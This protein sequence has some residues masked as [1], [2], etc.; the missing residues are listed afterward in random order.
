M[1]RALIFSTFLL[2]LFTTGLAP[3]LAPDG[4]DGQDA[5]GPSG[6]D[7]NDGLDARGPS[8]TNWNDGLDTRG[9][10]GTYGNDGQDAW[11]P[12]GTYGND[13]QDARGPSGTYGNDGQDARGPSGTY[14]N[15][16]QDAGGPSGTNGAEASENN[17]FQPKAPAVLDSPIG[18]IDM[19]SLSRLLNLAID[20]AP[21]KTEAGLD[22]PS[23]ILAQQIIGY[24]YEKRP[25]TGYHFGHGTNTIIFVGGLHGGYEWN[26]ILLAYQAI[27]YFTKHPNAV[28]EDVTLIIIPS[29][30]PDGQYA[31][32]RKEGP[33]EQGDVVPSTAAGR[34]NGRGVDLNRNWDCAWQP[35]AW[36]RDLV[37]SGGKKPFSEPES[38]ALRDFFLAQD[39]EV[40]IFWHS[41][42]G[43]V[44]AAGCQEP[45]QPSRDLA[46]IYGSASGY[47][48]ANQFSYY[49]VTGDAS[50]W[51][52]TQGIPSFT[53]ELAS[54]DQIEWTENQSGMMAILKHLG[55]P[56]RKALLPE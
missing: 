34:F 22:P 2:F 51:L 16:G 41:K 47:P 5:R 14:G 42:A 11:G 37:V 1:F 40:V 39:P 56:E 29:A 19:E 52:S 48:V 3:W 54:H 18:S 53:V 33:F 32:T 26:T 17:P 24:S 31:V 49:E 9:P 38:R 4:N 27:D 6:T 43:G 7:G 30:N 44:F 55:Q 35:D 15:E 20:P 21:L 45:F 36:W 13:G 50:D 23:P 28:P 46:D 25:I 10:S 12:S 8:G